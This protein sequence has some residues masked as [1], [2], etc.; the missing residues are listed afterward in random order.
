MFLGNCKYFNL[1]NFFIQSLPRQWIIYSKQRQVLKPQ[2]ELHWCC[3]TCTWRPQVQTI[4]LFYCM[5]VPIVFQ[6]LPSFMYSHP[7]LPPVFTQ[8]VNR[9]KVYVQCNF[10]FFRPF[11]IIYVYFGNKVN[12]CETKRMCFSRGKCFI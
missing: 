1:S 10:C 4:V 12:L 6:N 7:N 11:N 9:T 2:L 5:T 3:L 8:C